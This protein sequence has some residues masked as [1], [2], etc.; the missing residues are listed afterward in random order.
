M[1]ELRVYGASDDL[2]EFRGVFEEEYNAHGLVKFQLIV[3]LLDDRAEFEIG[4]RFHREWELSV[5]QCSRWSNLPIEV[6]FD[7]RADYDSDPMVIFYIPE[8]AS[9]RVVKDEDE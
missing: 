5:T 2:V 3:D 7:Q 4:A 9:V 1:N 6:R 8:G